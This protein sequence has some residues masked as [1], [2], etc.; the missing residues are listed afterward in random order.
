MEEDDFP[1]EYDDEIIDLGDDVQP[2]S[3][4]FKADPSLKPIQTESPHI[5]ERYMENP[6]KVFED[7]EILN[8]EEET[9]NKP[10]Y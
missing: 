1:D 6:G 7:D 10:F 2:F 8:L 5:D 4:S 9:E 3:M